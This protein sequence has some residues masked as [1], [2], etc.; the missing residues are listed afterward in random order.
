[1]TNFFFRAD[2][3]AHRV[4]FK[5]H[6]AMDY[7]NV[8][9]DLQ[10]EASAVVEKLTS[11]YLSPY[12]A[13]RQEILEPVSINK[14]TMLQIKLHFFKKCW[15][16]ENDLNFE[17]V[18]FYSPPTHLIRETTFS[19]KSFAN[20][21]ASLQGSAFMHM[22]EMRPIIALMWT[23]DLVSAVAASPG[24]TVLREMEYI[25]MSLMLDNPDANFTGMPYL[26]HLQMGADAR[27]DL[28]KALNIV[29]RMINHPKF[30]GYDIDE[31]VLQYTE[32]IARAMICLI[33]SLQ[34]SHHSDKIPAWIKDFRKLMVE[35]RSSIY[36]AAFA[37]EM[38]IDASQPERYEDSVE[39]IL[40]SGH[41]GC[42]LCHEGSVNSAADEYAVLPCC[43]H[44]FCVSC[45]STWI[46]DK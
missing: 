38:T 44:T 10:L 34:G 32:R 45:A 11:D 46:T 15:N 33:Y 3:S 23:Q 41:S 17:H 16:N 12:M 9:E 6:R 28:I 7:G 35:V 22:D 19:Y 27:M 36:F 14:I 8:P 2:C 39:E 31:D 18:V 5:T 13:Q 25:L 40:G 37:A 1:M 42:D 26:V 24:F 29:L 21:N 30:G 4:N 20:D 43:S